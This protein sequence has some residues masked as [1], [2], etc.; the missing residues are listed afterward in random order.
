MLLG[1]RSRSSV[2]GSSYTPAQEF[3]GLNNLVTIDLSP[4]CGTY[5]GDCARS[6]VVENGRVV[7]SSSALEM[8]EGINVVK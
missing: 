2:S 3:V 8:V 4:K 6:F 7:E 5:W 1:S